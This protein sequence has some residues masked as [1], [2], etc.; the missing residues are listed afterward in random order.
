MARNDFG[1]PFW[2]LIWIHYY[3]LNGTGWEWHLNNSFWMQKISNAAT[4]NINIWFLTHNTLSDRRKL[5]LTV[6]LL[7]KRLIQESLQTFFKLS[8][9]SFLLMVITTAQLH[10][11]KPEIRFCAG[12]NPS[13][14]V[15]DSR[16][17]GCL[18]MVSAGN[19]AKRLS[20]VNHTPKIVHHKFYSVQL[21][22]YPLRAIPLSSTTQ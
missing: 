19:K 10:S 15:G 9:F 7:L 12:S 8:P 18:T 2:I 20:S 16:W 11:T 17:W 6:L 3:L 21:I 1:Q 22:L 5:D 14:R 4:N 13:R